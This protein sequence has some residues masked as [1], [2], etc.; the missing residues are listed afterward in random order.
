LIDKTPEHP[1]I[2]FTSEKA[3]LSKYILA[4]KDANQENDL[5]SSLEYESLK[6]VREM[7]EESSKSDY[8]ALGLIIPEVSLD[9][10]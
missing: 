1:D 2:S 8:K 10:E 9:K 6:V 3:E 5:F 4:I 7:D